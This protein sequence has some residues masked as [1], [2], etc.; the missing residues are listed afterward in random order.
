MRQLEDY[1]AVGFETFAEDGT[2]LNR[3][4]GPGYPGD[5]LLNWQQGPEIAAIIPAP[6]EQVIQLH[7]KGK[8]WKTEMFPIDSEGREIPGKREQA[9]LIDVK[10]ES[11]ARTIARELGCDVYIYSYWEEFRLVLVVS[12]E[13]EKNYPE[14]DD[15]LIYSGDWD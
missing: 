9:T 3:M 13:N 12:S 10:N 5:W 14:S 8:C 11:E 2:L 7:D 4:A 6:Y 1:M 15:W